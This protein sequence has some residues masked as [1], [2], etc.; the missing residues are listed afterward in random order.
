MVILEAQSIPRS[1]QW[2]LCGVWFVE[3]QSMTVPV[4]HLQTVILATVAQI[5][6][7]THR[8]YTNKTIF[9]HI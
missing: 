5:L 3:R 9:S 2:L 6:Q 4:D 1:S 7:E 8:E